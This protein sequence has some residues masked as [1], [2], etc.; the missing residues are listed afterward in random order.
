VR[1]KYRTRFDAILNDVRQTDDLEVLDY[2]GHHVLYDV[3]CSAI[4]EPYR[5]EGWPRPAGRG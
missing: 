3:P 1:E 2:N 5:H 4:G